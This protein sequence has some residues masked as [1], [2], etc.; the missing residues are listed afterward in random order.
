MKDTII[1]I[2]IK[3]HTGR[4]AEEENKILYNWLEE[5]EENKK[6][7]DRI[8]DIWFAVMNPG[9]KSEY[10]ALS[11]LK[12]VKAKLSGQKSIFHG[13]VKKQHT[14]TR[15]VFNWFIRI[16]AILVIVFS[17]GTAGYFLFGDKMFNTGTD[18][19]T[20]I[21]APIGSKSKIT[22]SDGTKVWL[23]AGSTIKYKDNFNKKDRCVE[24][25]GEGYFDVVKN[26]ALTFTVNTHEIRIMALGTAFNVKAYPDEGSVE[27][28]LVSGS[29]IVEHVKKG[30]KMILAP[31]QRATYFKKE[32]NVY[33][34]EVE[35]KSIG[36]VRA[37][38]LQKIKGK[39][40]HIKQ[41]E[42]DVFTA[43][44]DNRLV[45]RNEPFQSLVVKLERWFDVEINILNKEI[46]DFHFNGTIENETIQDVM[47]I[48]KYA[49]PIQYNIKHNVITI[50]GKDEKTN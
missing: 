9:K 11:A 8:S 24:L 2:I 28:T 14:K 17:L 4:S 5:G 20:I 33:L 23:N 12:T 13:N 36:E 18:E 46:L 30:K 39:I 41:V 25:I 19:L 42:T 40:L 15:A 47:E 48:I 45:F 32:G 10:D 3:Y 44:K 27:T 35:S 22:L 7:F 37:E 49:L 43:W 21:T 1:E 31:N 6:Q 26:E 38:T 34:S 16:A 50:Y 29:L